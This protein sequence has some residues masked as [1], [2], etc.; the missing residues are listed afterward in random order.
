MRHR[1]SSLIN[2]VRSLAVTLVLCSLNL[3]AVGSAG[4]APRESPA[5]I[6]LSTSMPAPNQR[7][8]ITV[9]GL[10]ATSVA[11]RLVG[12]TDRNGNASPWTPLGLRS[13]GWHGDLAQPTLDGVYPIEL[14]LAP[15]TTPQRS[16]HWMLRVFPPGTLRGPSF[17]TPEAVAADWV[18]RLARSQTLAA[19]RSWPPTTLDRRDR[20]LNQLF[21][22]AY[23]EHNDNALAHRR[24]IWIT[25]V[26]DKYDGRWRLLEATVQPYLIRG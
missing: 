11:V 2:P 18:A 24:G 9:T 10:S 21:V 19:I 15:D 1:G 16:P 25:A 13:E 4:A 12:A 22:I 26:R 6:T 20:R 5:Q 7:V 23:S 3:S 8:S 17:A 14:R